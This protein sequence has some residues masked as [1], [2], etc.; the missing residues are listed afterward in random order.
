MTTSGTP[1]ST[2]KSVQYL[3]L[4]VAS[5]TIFF[6]TD[7]AD[8]FNSVKLILLLLISGWLIGLLIVSYKKS[9]IKLKSKDASELIRGELGS[10]VILHMFRPVTKE[11]ISFELT[12]ANIKLNDVPYWGLDE[13]N[14]GYIRIKKFSKNTAKG[15]RDAMVE[16]TKDGMEN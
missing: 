1:T 14:I 11:K 7:V 6:R 3:V 15:F 2:P 4:G 16:M 5:I 8:P 12:R 9:P 10:V 13:N